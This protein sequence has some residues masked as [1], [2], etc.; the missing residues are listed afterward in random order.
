MRMFFESMMLLTDCIADAMCNTEQRRRGKWL[1]KKDAGRTL[2]TFFDFVASWTC[3]TT[4]PI[5][6]SR[7]M[8]SADKGTAAPYNFRSKGC[9]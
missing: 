7:F 2:S 4:K 5:I 3:L 9:S 8:P 6:M 1:F